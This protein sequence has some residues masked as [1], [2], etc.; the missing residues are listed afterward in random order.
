MD[1]HRKSRQ[2][3]RAH[4]DENILTVL[5]LGVEQYALSRLKQTNG[6]RDR[7]V[8]CIYGTGTSASGCAGLVMVHCGN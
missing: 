7:G 5:N 1:A 8:P 2:T 3:T 4:I 6:D